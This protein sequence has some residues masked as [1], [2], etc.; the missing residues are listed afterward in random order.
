MGSRR[1]GAPQGKVRALE[2]RLTGIPGLETVRER[3]EFWRAGDESDSA[4]IHAMLLSLRRLDAINMAYGA[5]AGDGALAEVASRIAHF[6]GEE[7]DGHWLLARAG[8][9]SFVL[10]ANETCS[11]ERWQLIADQLAEAVSRP[12]TMPSGVLRLSP[13]IALVRTLADE[14]VD[15][16]LDR[17]SLALESLRDQQGTMLAWADGEASPPGHSAAQ[18]EADL[19][20]AIDR[21]E[22]EILFQ[23]QF[24]LADDRL[25]GAEALARWKHPQLG[26]IGAGALFA[27]AERADHMAPLSR[28]IAAKALAAAGGWPKSLRLSI[29]VTPADLAFGNYTR[30]ML[31][32]VRASGFAPRRL[33][34]EVTEQALIG[35]ITQAAQIMAEFSAQ[36]IRIALDDFGAGFCNFRYLKVLPIHYLKLDR[37]MIDG[38]TTDKR[39]VAVLRAIVAMAKALD[40]QVIAEGI[41]EEA[42][43]KV[44][45]REGCTY[46]QGFLR[47]QPM[48]VAMFAK[49]A[50][51]SG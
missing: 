28:H 17:L 45:A 16:M 6:A 46:Y 30:Q 5:D 12:V 19:L 26:R 14:S 10:V 36:G 18:L 15:S 23:P 51:S 13:R 35:D 25:T 11:R 22:I 40:L 27:I 47:A 50:R 4:H 34:L 41:E 8:G 33:T 39:D 38:I 7:L 20:G 3:V 2:D 32:L 1:D 37:S 24:S 48:S 44:A 43:R 49:L 42:Q 21:D 9:G 31:D 29:N